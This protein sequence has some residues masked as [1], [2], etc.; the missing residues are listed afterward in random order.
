[1]QATL[2]THE[3]NWQKKMKNLLST[4]QDQLNDVCYS[5]APL[6]NHVHEPMFVFSQWSEWIYWNK[7]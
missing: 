6:F 5:E 7:V 3:K 4:Y 2:K 1:M